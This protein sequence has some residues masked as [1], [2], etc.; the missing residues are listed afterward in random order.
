MVGSR[1]RKWGRGSQSNTSCLIARADP[2]VAVLTCESLF[3]H[4][5]FG[6]RVKSPRYSGAKESNRFKEN[7]SQ[8]Q[9]SKNLTEVIS[10]VSSIRSEQAVIPG[11]VTENPKQSDGVS[12]LGFCQIASC[13]PQNSGRRIPGTVTKTPEFRGQLS[14]LTLTDATMREF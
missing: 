11:T 12:G 4:G 5:I 10:D 14:K 13:Y 2:D 3:L 1:V 7:R 8:I 9:L 6:I